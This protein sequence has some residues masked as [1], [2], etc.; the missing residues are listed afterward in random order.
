LGKRIAKSTRVDH[1]TFAP[2]YLSSYTDNQALIRAKAGMVNI[3]K[4][5]NEGRKREVI[6]GVLT[7]G[8][9]TPDASTTC[10][11]GTA[12]GFK[13]KKG[14]TVGVSAS[15]KL[16]KGMKHAI[17]SREAADGN[18]EKHQ[19]E[20][21]ETEL[22]RCEAFIRKFTKETVDWAHRRSKMKHVMTSLYSWADTFGQVIGISTDSV[23][24]AFDA[25]KMVLTLRAQIIPVCEDLEKVVQEK[26]LPQFSLL[27][28]SMNDPL[29][30][31]EAMH[32]SFCPLMFPNSPTPTF[33][34][35]P[36]PRRVPRSVIYGAPPTV[37]YSHDHTGNGNCRE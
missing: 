13:P 16:V 10:F 3:A 24:E 18:E 7:G 29:R 6:K 34:G 33:G 20:K 5:V 15:V 23:S 25:F 31:L 8:K 9:S 14:L 32:P 19:V 21:M 28:D 37:L 12:S 35:I 30:L 2:I 27:V 1:I 4:D 26:L 22:K 36:V 11:S 17:R